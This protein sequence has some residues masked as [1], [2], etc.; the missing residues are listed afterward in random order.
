MDV[1]S[2]SLSLFHIAASLWSL[3]DTMTPSWRV[4]TRLDG[5]VCL[6]VC[7]CGHVCVCVCVL[8]WHFPLAGHITQVNVILFHTAL[9]QPQ[10]VDHL[11]RS[12]YFSLG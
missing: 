4:N 9:R 2:V 1:F 12:Y 11:K 7:V 8:L 3:C 6:S 10:G 5:C